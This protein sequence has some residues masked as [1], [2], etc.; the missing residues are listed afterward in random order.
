MPPKLD[1]VAEARIDRLTGEKEDL[2]RRL[3]ERDERIETLQKQV[4]AAQRNAAKSTDALAA[5]QLRG[6]KTEETSDGLRNELADADKRIAVLSAS[7]E[8]AEAQM[9]ELKKQQAAAAKH[10]HELQTELSAARVE[11]EEHHASRSAAAVE[12]EERRKH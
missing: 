5:E 8:R 11:L 9:S 3:K 7:L 4:A 12:E 6:S 2:N 1:P 10:E